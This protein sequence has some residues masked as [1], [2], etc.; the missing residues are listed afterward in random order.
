MISSHGRKYRKISKNAETNQRFRFKKEKEGNTGDI[1]EWEGHRPDMT[2]IKNAKS[3]S[4]G[5]K[6]RKTGIPIKS[7]KGKKRVQ[8][9]FWTKLIRER[10]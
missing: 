6:R 8:K 9:V 1:T 2:S 3:F 10:G 5:I 4:G 7:R